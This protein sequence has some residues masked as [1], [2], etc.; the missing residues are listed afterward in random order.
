M[1]I[2]LGS[3]N[4]SGVDPK[5]L[6]AITLAN[7]GYTHSYGDDD[8]TRRAID[9]F[10]EVFGHDIDVYF[11]LTG[12]GANVLSLQNF[13]KPY[14]AVICAQSAHINVDECGA[15]E[16]FTGSKLISVETKQGKLSP[17]LLEKAIF[18][19]GDEHHVQPRIISL[20]QVTELGSV[21]TPAEIKAIVDFAHSRGLYVHLDGARLAN[22]VV[23]LGCSFADLTT[24]TGI[25]I[26]SFGATKNGAMLAESIVCFRPDLSS[27]MK[28]LR[29]MG[30]QLYSKMRYSSVQWLAYLSDNLWYE[31]A[32]NA[33]D[34]AKYL[35]SKLAEIPEVK[36]T[37]PLGANALFALL[38]K[39]IIEPLREEYYFYT[40]DEFTGEI[41]LMC[42]FDTRKE[43]ID[44][45]LGFLQKLID[46]F[47]S[48]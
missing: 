5:I 6:E 25:D 20:S 44:K 18:G 23:A 35:Y 38:P 21:Y 33:N 22:A 13:L 24:H 26:L 41:R 34:M 4:H 30:M 46:S 1:K 29:K 10:K 15:P 28:F 27:G 31:N 39:E 42:S 11:V 19:V 16:H 8:Y 36:L 3:D 32:K 2:S 14:E 17:E 48:H 9:K 37:Q 7:V 43:D 12:T 45:F 40:W 47:K